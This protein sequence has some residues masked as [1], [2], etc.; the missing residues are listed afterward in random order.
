MK[1]SKLWLIL[2]VASLVATTGGFAQT[3]EDF[4]S[5]INFAN[6]PGGWDVFSCDANYVTHSGAFSGGALVL[7]REGIS[8]GCGAQYTLPTTQDWTGKQ[9][10]FWVNI[11][12]VEFTTINFQVFD[13][14]DGEQWE[15]KVSQSPQQGA[16]V[17]FVATISPEYFHDVG[18]GGVGDDALDVTQI[19]KFNIILFNNGELFRRKVMFD[20]FTLQDVPTTQ[21]L[22]ESFEGTVTIEDPS[23][24]PTPGAWN[25]FSCDSTFLD[26][27]LA[28]DGT[29]SFAIQRDGVSWGCGMQYA[30]PQAQDWTGKAVSVW[31]HIDSTEFTGLNFQIFDAVDNE[32]WEQKIVT[33]PLA[34]GWQQIVA[35]IDPAYYHDVGNGGLGDKNLDVTQISKFNIIFLNRGENFRRQINVDDIRIIDSPIRSLTDAHTVEDFDSGVTFEGPS[36][37]PTPGLWNSFSCD[38]AYVSA[39]GS[40]SGQALVIEREGVSWGCGVQYALPA[41]ENW[42]GKNVSFW[43]HIDTVEFTSIN[44]QV[45]DAIDGEQCE[46]RVSQSP[47]QGEWVEFVAQIS[48]EYFHDVGNGGLGNGRLDVTQIVKFNL[49]VLNNGE[50]FR[51]TIRFDEIRLQD[52]FDS[53]PVIEDFEGTVTFEDPSATPTPGVWNSFS[54]DTV[55]V[56]DKFGH[57][58]SSS[59]VIKKAGVG[60]GCGAQYALPSTQDWTDMA[61]IVWIYVDTVEFT[62]YNFQVFDAVDGEQWEQ[63]IVT[64]PLAKGWQPIVAQ[65]DPAYFVDNGNGGVGDGQPDPS[66]IT[67]FNIIFLNRGENFARTFYVDDI[68]VIESELVTSIINDLNLIPSE[69]T[70]TQNYPNPFNPTTTIEYSLEN[71]AEIQLSI[72]NVLGQKIR[73]LVNG[74]QGSGGHSI[75]W[76]G[77]NDAGTTVASGVYV[78]V[79]RSDEVML[80]RKLMLLK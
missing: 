73:T 52:A 39:D 9:V 31:I 75:Q 19:T 2:F 69:F 41:P 71:T 53:A 44:F 68:R 77:R 21:P 61:A 43:V 10:S 46:Q 28:H 6:V 55:F 70:L 32:Q 14:V 67:K 15:Q 50:N 58:G 16:W 38:S 8:W 64:N 36:A 49:I 76:N 12:S 62:G 20:E 18:N 66:Q 65:I 26:S 45:F 5:E 23:A 57:E 1:Y 11:D 37:T 35:H 54:S 80:S 48:P 17:E 78:Y 74:K 13:A 7:E 60:W 72:F 29:V 34:Q 63:K 24:T 33:N 56:T 59:L 42:R 51:R 25:T 3:I 4:N 30:L 47:Q 27:S 22:V 40:L 79:L